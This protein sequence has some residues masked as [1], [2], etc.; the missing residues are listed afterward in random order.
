LRTLKT[1]ADSDGL[2]AFWRIVEYLADPAQILPKQGSD[3]TI[4]RASTFEYIPKKEKSHL[5][6]KDKDK[7]IYLLSKAHQD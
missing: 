4:E 3:F 2:V 6:N 5:Y 7:H 1:I